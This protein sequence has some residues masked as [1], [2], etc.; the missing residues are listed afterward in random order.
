MDTQTGTRYTIPASDEVHLLEFHFGN[1]RDQLRN[2]VKRRGRDHAG[3][4]HE[5]SMPQAAPPFHT[6][7]FQN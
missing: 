7:E 1:R 6:T 4:F 3:F 5:A 2:P